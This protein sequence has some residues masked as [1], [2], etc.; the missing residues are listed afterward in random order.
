MRENDGSLSLETRARF[1]AL[2]YTRTASYD[3]AISSY[4]ASQ[5]SNDDLDRLEPLNPLG[6]PI[7]I[8]ASELEEG[9]TA[10]TERSGEESFPEYGIVELAKVIDLRY[11]ENPHQKGALYSDGSGGGIAEAE[12]LHGKEM[13]FNNYVDAE[14]AWNLVNDFDGAVA[15]V[16][17]TNPSGVGLGSSALEAYKRALSTDPV[18]LLAASSPVTVRLTP[19]SHQK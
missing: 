19:Q 15:I 10:E 4:L 16:K 2:A 18:S 13:W 5:L 6:D 1:A 3:L 7:F 12:Q 14:A 11:G 9:D 8:D 17:H